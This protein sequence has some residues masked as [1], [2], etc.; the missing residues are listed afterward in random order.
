MRAL[1]C[2][3]MLFFLTAVIA[4]TTTQKEKQPQQNIN[5]LLNAQYILSFQIK[6]TATASIKLKTKQQY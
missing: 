4:N 6:A 2:P 5:K 3:P 1:A